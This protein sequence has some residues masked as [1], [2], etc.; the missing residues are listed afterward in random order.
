MCNGFISI[1][2]RDILK[3]VDCYYLIDCLKCQLSLRFNNIYFHAFNDILSIYIEKEINIVEII[4]NK[5]NDFTGNPDFY[6][7]M[8]LEQWIESFKT[9]DLETSVKVL[10]K[11]SEN[12][13]F[14]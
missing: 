5:M 12:Y 9:F 7:K 14:I 4:P 13:M 6:M 3:S 2:N 8:T 11:F 10:N 1:R